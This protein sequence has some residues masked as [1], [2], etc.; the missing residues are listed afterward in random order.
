MALFSATSSRRYRAGWLAVLLLVAS[1]PAFA[2]QIA[3]PTRPISL[4]AASSDFDYRNKLLV[5][6]KVRITQGELA[7]EADEAT[8][9]GL[10]FENS[11]WTFRGAVHISIPDGYL[12]SEAATVTFRDNV[13][14]RARI[15]GDPAEFEQRHAEAAQLARGR[16]GTIEYDVA[17][18]TVR[19]TGH[20]WLTD[21][22]NE[23][24][25]ETLVYNIGEERV[26]ANPDEQEGQGVSIV[27]RPRTDDAKR[28][29]PPD[30]GPGS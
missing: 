22:Q 30:G 4:D 1:W 29:P 2:V 15:T 10:N 24:T 5:F 17:G 25:G 20:A 6:R 12:D 14:T 26:I 19:L 3:D 8:A 28:T 21:G 11:D 13:I 16:A 27:I 9:T 7:V 18:Q 23:I